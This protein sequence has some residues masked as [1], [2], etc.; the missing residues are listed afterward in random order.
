MSEIRYFTTGV[1]NTA[2][3]VGEE[4]SF[5][6]IHKERLS[7]TKQNAGR[8]KIPGLLYDVMTTVEREKTT[9]LFCHTLR[10]RP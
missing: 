7:G 9:T 10:G 4:D 6:D 2:G 3:I 8:V 1:N 5:R